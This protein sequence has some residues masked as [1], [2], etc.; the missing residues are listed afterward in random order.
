MIDERKLKFRA[1]SSHTGHYVEGF[2]C[3]MQLPGS[4]LFTPCIQKIKEWDS[5]DYLDYE[6]IDCDTL[7]NM[8]DIL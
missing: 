2:F 8:F 3:K 5:G 1:K 6:P 4:K 7:E